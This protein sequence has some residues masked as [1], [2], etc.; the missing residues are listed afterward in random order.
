MPW[1]TA[2]EDGVKSTVSSIAQNGVKMPAGVAG[3]ASSA[4][5]GS[6]APPAPPKTSPSLPSVGASNTP[7][8]GDSSQSA[9]AALL[10]KSTQPLVSQ[11]KGDVSA[12]VDQIEH[13][14]I[15]A[16]LGAAAGALLYENN[17]I[18]AALAGFAA[19]AYI[20]SQ[21]NL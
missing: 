18:A 9:L 3:T 13:T 14:A 12:Q 1:Y 19:G 15:F 20:G 17:R 2:I 5:P 11:I 16:A 8:S 21:Q 10:L 7:V 6:S 4:S